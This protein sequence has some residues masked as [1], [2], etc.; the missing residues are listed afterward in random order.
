MGVHYIAANGSEIKN[1][2]EKRLRAF[3]EKGLPINMTWQIAEVKKPLASIGRICDAG[4]VAVL[5]EKG[6][7]IVGKAGAK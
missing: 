1:E 5:T 2:G 4:N 6:G 7:Y 3:T